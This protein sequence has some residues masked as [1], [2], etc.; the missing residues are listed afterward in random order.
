MN[1]DTDHEVRIMRLEEWGP[2]T[3]ACNVCGPLKPGKPFK[4][5]S[6]A[7][8]YHAARF[9]PTPTHTSSC[10]GP[11]GYHWPDP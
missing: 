6:D 11:L 7:H 1:P 3:A 5:A 10:R 4:T 2:V 8:E 9:K